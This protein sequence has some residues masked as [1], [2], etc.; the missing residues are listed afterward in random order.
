MIH[1]Y[2]HIENVLVNDNIV[3][4][5]KTYHFK[6]A[7]PKKTGCMIVGFSGNNG[8]T[9]QAT[10]LANK[11]NISWE[12]KHGQK[13]ANF[14]GSLSQSAVIPV[15]RTG[16]N[17][18]F[19]K[20]FHEI[21]D[22]IKP[23]DIVLGGW[24]IYKNDLKGSMKE[25]E[26]LHID[27]Q[28]KIN[29]LNNQTQALP[30]IY[31]PDFIAKNQSD[32]ANNIIP[33]NHA[34]QEH[35]QKIR[36]DI[37]EFKA[38]HNL[39]CVVVMFSATTEKYMKLSKGVHDTGENIIRAIQ[40]N[41][42]EISPSLMFGVAAVLEKCIFLNGGPQNT[43]VPGLIDLAKINKTFVGGNDFKTG[44]TKFKAMM[45]D[46]LTSSGFKLNSIVSYNHLGNNDG[47]NLSSEE[48]FKSKEKSKS[49]LIGN[50]VSSNKT[51]F[52]DEKSFP[53]HSVTIKY[54]PNVKDDKRAVDEYIAEICMGAEQTIST[55]NI[56]PD[57]LLAVPIMID[58][59]IFSEWMS[60]L[61]V[62]SKNE[63]EFRHL[64]TVLSHLSFFF[65]AACVNKGE[66]EQ[67]ALFY[68]RNNLAQLILSSKGLT[69][70][71]PLLKF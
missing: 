43:I 39:D 60:R 13:T 45:T 67:N 30:S 64:P 59:V 5:K 68:Q 17:D 37:K 58:L 11:H 12:T 29:S 23:T 61:Q 41:H 1:T 52:P 48:Q 24:D 65:K 15:G 33:G 32:R 7:P 10:I 19:Y 38:K 54:V 36:T 2:K 25:S 31:Y 20:H 28:N 4:Q 56:C 35:L 34:C 40:T 50:I 44:Q 18:I 8:S 63:L 49:D 51:L 53:A 46:F 47:L 42:L 21:A 9:L 14:L 69:V 6:D 57:S 16:K 55:Y 26:V 3:V 62:K 22:F 27:L 66:V 71:N 70:F